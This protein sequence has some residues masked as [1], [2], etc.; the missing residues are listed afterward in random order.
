MTS[1]P[2][3][4]SKPPRCCL[5]GL[6]PKICR[7]VRTNCTHS[8]HADEA[9]LGIGKRLDPIPTDLSDAAVPSLGKPALAPRGDGTA[10]SGGARG[11]VLRSVIKSQV[12]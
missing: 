8:R 11:E 5:I 10:K 7:Q 6:N 1:S 9:L 3:S 12:I 2:Q 4:T